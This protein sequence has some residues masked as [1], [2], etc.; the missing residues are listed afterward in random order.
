[1]PT[2]FDGAD[3]LTSLDLPVRYPVYQTPVGRIVQPEA[4]DVG[5]LGPALWS[6]GGDAS[7]AGLGVWDRA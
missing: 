3:E 6:A 1:M 5:D 7:Q 4:L 2:L